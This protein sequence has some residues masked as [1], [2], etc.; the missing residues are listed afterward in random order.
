MVTRL[1]AAPGLPRRRRELNRPVRNGAAIP[2]MM[3]APGRAPWAGSPYAR[4]YRRG[5]EAHIDLAGHGVP[6]PGGGEI[7]ITGSPI[8]HEPGSSAVGRD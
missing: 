7:L 1:S 4:G 5:Q 6:E 8:A 2:P 3:C